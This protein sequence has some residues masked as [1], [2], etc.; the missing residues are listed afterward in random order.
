MNR[1]LAIAALC[2]GFVIAV[3]AWPYAQLSGLAKP[4]RISPR[5][6]APG[7]VATCRHGTDWSLDGEPFASGARI[8]VPDRVGGA[9]VCRGGGEPD[10]VGITAKPQPGNILLVILD[11]VGV[12][13]VGLYDI[14]ETVPK[15]PTLDKLARRGLTF[16]RA[17]SS[18]SCTPT[19]AAIL[20]GQH[21]MNTGI[22]SPLTGNEHGLR[23]REW[24]LPEALDDLTDEAYTHAAIGK[25]HLTTPE[26]GD[27][28]PN[29]MGFDHYVGNIANMS[30]THRERYDNWTRVVNGRSKRSKKYATT[31]N[32]DETLAFIDDAGDRPWFVWLAFNSAHVPLHWPPKSLAGDPPAHLTGPRKFDAMVETADKELGRLLSTMDRDVRARTTVIVI[33]DNGTATEAVRPPTTADKAKFSIFQGGIH[34]PLIVSGPSVVEPGRTVEALTLHVDLFETILELAGADLPRDRRQR[35]DGRSIVRHLTAVDPPAHRLFVY[36]ESFQPNGFDL[37]KRRDWNRAVIHQN[38][39]LVRTPDGRDALHHLVQRGLDGPDLL[40]RGDVGDEGREALRTMRK[41]LE[42]RFTPRQ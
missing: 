16:T 29:Q 30:A 9:L 7:D 22:G 40:A 25:W 13:R 32:V 34:V 6:V 35:I 38:W 2:V 15:T 5:M 33:G 18:P 4:A 20:T 8:T 42:N 31:D 36:V 21:A 26:E 23:D 14:S 28:K 19:R 3:L 41:A 27:D 39:K 37:S 11:D 12:D 24:I 17:Y 1:G 10:V